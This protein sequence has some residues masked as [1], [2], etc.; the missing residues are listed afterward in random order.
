MVS[1]ARTSPKCLRSTDQHFSKSSPLGRMWRI[2]TTSASEVSACAN[3]CRIFSKHCLTCSS[4]TAE[5]R[6]NAQ[7]KPVVPDIKIEPLWTAPRA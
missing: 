7:S 1:A 5:M 2:R 6:V 3:A 4:T